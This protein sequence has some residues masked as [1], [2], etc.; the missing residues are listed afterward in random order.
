VF[1]AKFF[2]GVV[3]SPCDKGSDKVAELGAA[4]SDKLQEYL[5]V[6]EKVSGMAGIHTLHALT[7]SRV[8]RA[9]CFN[10]LHPSSQLQ[11][12]TAPASASH[13]QL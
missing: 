4:V 12:T 5:T 3:P 11:P 2:G 10:P 1:V 9:A 6:M 8:C 13:K 7:T